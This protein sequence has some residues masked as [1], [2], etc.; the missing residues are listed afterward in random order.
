MMNTLGHRGGTGTTGQSVPL[1]A[2]QRQSQLRD[3][4]K[5]TAGLLECP[6]AK[7]LKQCLG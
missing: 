4:R 2:S 3:L 1:Q 6:A 5:Q 7:T